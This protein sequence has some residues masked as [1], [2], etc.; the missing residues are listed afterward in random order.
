MNPLRRLVTAVAVA[1]AMVFALAATAS[2]ASVPDQADDVAATTA[3]AASPPSS[4]GID[5]E[6]LR[7]SW[8]DVLGRIYQM[9]RAT[10]T[11]LSEHAQVLTYDGQRL[12]LGIATVGLANAFRNG[13]HAAAGDDP[14]SGRCRA[15]QHSRTIELAEHLVRDRIFVQ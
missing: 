7:R 11:F 9:R 15:Q 3:P 4:G 2:A 6:A 14:C 12:V 10:W 13:S 5:V 1:V 8:P